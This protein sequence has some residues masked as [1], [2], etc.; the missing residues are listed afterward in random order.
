MFLM[1]VLIFCETFFLEAIFFLLFEIGRVCS[2]CG[3]PT[4]LTYLALLS[5]VVFRNVNIVTK[6]FDSIFSKQQI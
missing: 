6:I 2:L 1:K 3:W 5:F 4:S